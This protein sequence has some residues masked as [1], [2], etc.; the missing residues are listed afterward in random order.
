M[1]LF[2]LV[3]LTENLPTQGLVQGMR[4]VIV[5]IHE[6]PTLAYEVEFTDG[7]GRTLTQVALLPSQL[8]P[9]CAERQQ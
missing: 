4:G 3:V 1:K 8:A 2:D 6:K 5:M 7:E 9:V